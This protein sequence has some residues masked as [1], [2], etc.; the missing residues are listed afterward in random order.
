MCRC[1]QALSPACPLTYYCHWTAFPHG[2][3]MCQ[4]HLLDLGVCCQLSGDEH[5]R[6]P[7][8]LGY[9]WPREL[10]AAPRLPN[11]KGRT[12]SAGMLSTAMRMIWMPAMLYSVIIVIPTLTCYGHGT[13]G[14]KKTRLRRAFRL[15]LEPAPNFDDAVCYRNARRNLQQQHGQC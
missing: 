12:D 7:W 1:V 2:G 10:R 8:S 11:A 14:S 15:G 9:S 4:G 5:Q 3:K 13:F 6:L